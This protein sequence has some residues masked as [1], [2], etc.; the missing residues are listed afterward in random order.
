[1]E[2][3][4]VPEAN[5]IEADISKKAQTLQTLRNIYKNF[6]SKNIYVCLGLQ[7]IKYTNTKALCKNIILKYINI[8]EM[9]FKFPR[10][11]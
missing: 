5:Q 3:K 7:N 10:T 9:M 1:M 8:I 11:N 2:S 4:D 6:I